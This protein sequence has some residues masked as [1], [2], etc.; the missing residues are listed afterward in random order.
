MPRLFVNFR[1][2]VD[3]RH[4]TPIFVGLKNRIAELERFLIRW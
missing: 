2:R 1:A 4:E 3:V